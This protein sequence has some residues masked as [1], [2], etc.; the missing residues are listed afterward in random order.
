MLIIAILYLLLLWLIFFRLKLL[1]FNWPWRIT[2][3][4]VGAAIL[5]VFVAL[6]NSMTPSGRV[7]VIG[8][9]VE[10]T[11]EVAGR[12]TAIPVQPNTLVKA[13]SVLFEIERTPYGNKLSNCR[14]HWRRVSKRSSG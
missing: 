14:R 4:I 2:S 8:R 7:A 1:P 13:G 9:V 11:P 10:V 3:V 6:L 5:A 12:V